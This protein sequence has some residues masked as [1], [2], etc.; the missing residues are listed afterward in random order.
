MWHQRHGAHQLLQE[1]MDYCPCRNTFMEVGANILKDL[2]PGEVVV[3]CETQVW[4]LLTLGSAQVWILV[5]FSSV[6]L[7]LNPK[8][9]SVP[10]VGGRYWGCW[11]GLGALLRGRVLEL[12]ALRGCLHPVLFP[13]C[14]QGPSV[15]SQCCHCKG[16]GWVLQG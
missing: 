16:P 11:F 2:F 13:G 10:P 7:R 5:W 8:A 12:W 9:G 6:G 15:S 1:N 4:K 3:I 14:A